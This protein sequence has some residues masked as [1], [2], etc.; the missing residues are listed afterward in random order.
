M[1]ATFSLFATCWTLL[2]VE[3]LTSGAEHPS[4]ILADARDFAS[5]AF[6]VLPL[7]HRANFFSGFPARRL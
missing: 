7:L 5:D 3:L 1:V 6:E 2:L 4:D